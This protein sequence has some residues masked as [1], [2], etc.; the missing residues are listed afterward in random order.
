MTRAIIDTGAE[1]NPATGDTIRVAMGKINDNF[2]EL[3]TDVAGA[4]LGGKLI[5]PKFIYLF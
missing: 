2:L 5:N 1:G 3:F 4:G